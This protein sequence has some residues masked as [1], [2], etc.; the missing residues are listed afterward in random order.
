MSQRGHELRHSGRN[1]TDD[2]YCSLIEYLA[3]PSAAMIHG[4]VL[5][6]TG[7]SYGAA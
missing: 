1:V 7:G 3:G 4:Q 2:D 5:F 6:V